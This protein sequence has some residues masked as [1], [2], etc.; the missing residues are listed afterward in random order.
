MPYLDVR[1]RLSVNDLRYQRFTDSELSR[2]C[3][4]SSTS[5]V[6]R[7]KANVLHNSIRQVN[8]PICFPWHDATPTPA[9]VNCI[10]HVDQHRAEKQVIWSHAWRIVAL[11]AYGHAS[12]DRSMRQRVREAVGQVSMPPPIKAAISI[13]IASRLPFPATITSS[14]VRPEA[15]F[16]GLHRL[17]KGC[18]GM[19]EISRLIVVPLAQAASKALFA[20]S[21]FRTRFGDK[22]RTHR[23][24]LL[25]VSCSGLFTQRRGFCVSILPCGEV[26]HR[27]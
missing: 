27:L 15:F 4:L 25:P 22:L 1:P 7:L 17:L 23:E 21:I 26:C 16:G 20:A 9:L 6:G 12:R 19:S 5:A 10:M 2:E 14:D 11:M 18:V 24:L 13:W 8:I 3:G